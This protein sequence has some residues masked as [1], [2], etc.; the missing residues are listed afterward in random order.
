[1]RLSAGRY[2]Q[3]PIS[4]SVQYL[5]LTGDDRSVWNNTMN[6]GFYSPFHPIPGISSGQYD[7]SWES[8]LKGTDMSFKITPFYTWVNDWQQQTFIGSGFVTQVPVGVNRDEGVE[9]QFTKGDFARNGLSGLIS[10]TYTSS[11]VM[12]QNVP[13]ST[14]G[15]I[16]NE[17]IAL[18]QA[19]SQYN[20]LTKGGGG[21]PCYQAGEAVSCSTPNGKIASGYDTILNPYYNLSQQG[22]INEG[23]WYNPWS[24]AIA[25]NLNGAVASYISPWVGAMILN[26]RHDKLAVTP[27][28]NFQSGGFYGSPLDTEG[29]DPRTCVQN[30]LAS[31][32]TKLSPK[33]NPLQCNYLSITAPGLGPFSYLYIPN[34]QTGSFLFDDVRQPNSIVGNLQITYDL[35]SKIRLTVLGA[36]LFR[37]CF[38]GTTEPWTTAFPPSNVFCG[39]SPTGGSLNSTIYPANFY[40]GTSVNDVKANGARLPY[41][42]QQS[43]LP[44]GAT[45]AGLGAPP[46]PINVYINAQVRI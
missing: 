5:S 42:F 33:T 12:F 35:S 31:G 41:A 1:M 6:L 28:F 37:A 11:K 2:T 46:S 9:F 19:I 26:Y 29:L 14:G 32:I 27:S 38:G 13:T 23:G 39:Y 17:L 10:T 36:N 24:T 21:S 45:N 4:A 15:T 8:H 43:Y 22:A 30:S 7:L 3:P 40:N 18:N 44:T 16:P 20:A 34:P 25:P